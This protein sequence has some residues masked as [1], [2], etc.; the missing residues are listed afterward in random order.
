MGSEK[1]TT[2]CDVFVVGALHLDVIVSA[3]SLPRLD[4]TLV[5]Q[6]VAYAFGGKGGN[7]AAAAARM[8]AAVAMAGR[9]GSDGFADRLLAELDCARVDR[10]QVIRDPGASGM[11][12]AIVDANGDY[13][14]VIVSAANLLIDPAQ[15][16]IPN[17]TKLVMLQNEVAEPVNAAIAAQAARQGI[18][19]LW[20]AAPARQKSDKSPTQVRHLILNRIEASDMTGLT[21]PQAAAQMLYQ[22]GFAN[23]L[24]TLGADGA[25]IANANGTDHRPGF[26]VPVISTHGAGDMFCGALAAELARGEPIENAVGF[27]QAAAALHVAAP[28]DERIHI[29]P[30]QTRALLQADQWTAPHGT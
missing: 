3:P 17:G 20:N 28:I 13:G 16:T 4:E 29:T 19:V 23:V 2:P 7:Q 11:S 1:M 14:A 21:D 27:A 18:P 9:V 24:I 5:G 25:M 15:I 22:E 8:G 12:V 30:A 10:S 26:N 6:S